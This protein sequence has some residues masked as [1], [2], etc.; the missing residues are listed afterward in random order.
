MFAVALG[1]AGVPVELHV[2]PDGIHAFVQMPMLT[3]ARTAIAQLGAFARR[4]LT[5][6]TR[7]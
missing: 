5:P 2:V 6:R 3:M 7:A 4:A 1:N